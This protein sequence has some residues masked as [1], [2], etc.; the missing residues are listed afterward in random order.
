MHTFANPSTSATG[1]A[2][3]VFPVPARAAVCAF[4]METS[5][6]RHVVG[7]ARERARAQAEYSA[8]VDDGKWAGL[9]E[10]AANDS[11]YPFTLSTCQ[12]STDRLVLVFTMS[13]GS[14]PAGATVVTELTVSG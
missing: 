14:I 7:V 9:V 3:Y 12:S 6:G 13:V 2:K 10:W 5:D 8:A 4:Q 1:Q 11:S